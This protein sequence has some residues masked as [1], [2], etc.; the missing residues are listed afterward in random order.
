MAYKRIAP[1]DVPSGGSGN[2][3]FSE[4]SVLLGGDP[5]DGPLG[6]SPTNTDVGSVFTSNGADSM[7]T[8]QPTS[9]ASTFRFQ[10]LAADPGAPQNGQVWYNTT[11]NLFKGRANGV[12]YTFDVT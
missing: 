1:L 2:V 7:P 10:L 8:F 9:M 5:G 6:Y 11:T 3:S 4:F 12:T